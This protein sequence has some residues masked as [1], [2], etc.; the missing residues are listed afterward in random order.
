MANTQTDDDE[1]KRIPRV[2]WGAVFAGGI[3]ALSISILLYLLGLGLGF[4]VIDPV[5]ESKPLS[6]L[7][8][9]T[10]IWWIITNLI[11]LFL[12]GMVAGRT[13]GFISKTDGGMHGFL[14]WCV[15]T[16]VCLFFI[17]SLTTSIIRGVS[18]TVSSIFGGNQNQKVVVQVDN[19]QQSNQQ[20]NQQG[21]FSNIR[22]EVIQLINKAER[23]NILPSDASENVNEALNE[24]TAE[25][26]E[27]WQE[28]NLDQ[29]IEQF[30]NDISVKIENGNLNI[31]VDGD[32]IKK[33]E[34]KDYLAQNTDLSEQEIE[35]MINEWNQNIEQ[36][37]TKVENLYQEAKQKV[38]KYSDQ[39]ADTIATISLV[40]FFA[41]I[42][43]AIAAW[44]GGMMAA[45]SNPDLIEDDY[46]RR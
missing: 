32:Y 6:G 19:Q 24:G 43:G 17:I 31:S 3:A 39:L 37:V 5:S 2:S 44:F 8:T 28:L 29:N 13:A 41:L 25:M 34:I 12:G 45:K 23:Y 33:Q 38:E 16:A 22:N 9:G 35:Q 18:G 7:G 21:F 4:T 10:I 30:F 26:Q 20:Q 1:T 42:A 11:A 15:Y 14:S 36:A 27:M 46:V 40:S